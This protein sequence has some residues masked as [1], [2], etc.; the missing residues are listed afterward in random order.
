VNGPVLSDKLILY[1]TAGSGTGAASGD[2]AEVFNTR[3]DTYLWA[4]LVAAGSG[5]AETVD[6]TELPPRF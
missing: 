2:P 4:Q 6:T 5:R 1:R 3:P